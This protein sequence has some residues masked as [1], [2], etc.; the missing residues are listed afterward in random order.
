MP[1]LKPQQLKGM[2]RWLGLTG[3]DECRDGLQRSALIL[4]ATQGG[5]R[6]AC[7]SQKVCPRLMRSCPSVRPS[8]CR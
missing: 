3:R 6:R 4:A 7:C 1:V 8:V 2:E 5:S